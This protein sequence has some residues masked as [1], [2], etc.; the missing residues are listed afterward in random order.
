MN[1][2][3]LRNELIRIN[4]IVAERGLIRSSD[5][6]ISAR[7]DQE[8]LLVSPSGVYK[9]AMR[10]E[11]LIIIDMDGKVRE[12]KEE[13]HPTSETLMHLEAY[14]QR[15]DINAV[16]H[17]HP[18]FSTALTISGRPFPVEYIPEVLIALGEVPTADYATP[19][20]QGLA[21]SIHDLILQHNCILLS[22]H[23]SLTV[24]STLEEALVAVE[25]MEHAAYTLWISQAFGAPIPLA[26]EELENLRQ[27]GSQ[28]RAKH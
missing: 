28:L 22:H 3:A 25:R 23:G 12:A 6:N 11:D 19:G 17:A 16:I 8:R 1:E 15:P 13:L 24:G 9:S 2:L 7:L 18:P 27:I 21:D 5:G 20:T 14:R 4:R 10:P 26:P